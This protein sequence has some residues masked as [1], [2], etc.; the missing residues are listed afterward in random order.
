MVGHVLLRTCAEH[1]DSYGTVRASVASEELGV[2]ADRIVA[3]VT[4][5]EIGSVARAIEI[6][7]PD[8]VVN[9]I[10]VVKQIETAGDPVTSIAVNALFPHQL[11]ALSRSAGARLI[12]LSTDCVFTGRRGHYAETHTPDAEN[13]YGRSKLLGEPAGPSCVTIRSSYIGPEL[14]TSHGLLEWF[15]RQRG[16]V[17]GFRRAVFSGFTT[18]AFS[19]MVVLMILNH[20]GLTG[21]WHVAS[22]PIT[23]FDLLTLIKDAYGLPVRIEPDDMVVCDR[24][25]NGTRFREATGYSSPAWPAMIAELR[26][27]ARAPIP[28]LGGR[29]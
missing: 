8:V 5:E 3:G 1:F 17:R 28:E 29:C 15:L 13:L 9:C 21:V 23:K 7:R 10:G 26:R 24:T 14:R 27:R 18:D 16:A 25:L 6:S 12:H 11:A 20:P 19:Q 22:E 2:P 4:A